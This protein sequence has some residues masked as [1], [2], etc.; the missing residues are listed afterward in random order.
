[1]TAMRTALVLSALLIL[2]PLSAISGASD[3]FSDSH[4]SDT[5]SAG[6]QN[7]VFAGY[8]NTTHFAQIYYPAND[9]GLGQ[10][11]DNASGPYPLLIWIGDEGEANDQYDWIGKSLATAGYITVV[12]PPDWNSQETGN[13][14][15]SILNLWFRLQYNNQN[16]SLQGDPAN[17]RDAFNLNYWGIGGHGVGAKQAV[18][19]Q[20]LMTG[21]LEPYITNPP[22][23]AFIGLGLED[24]STDIRDADLGSSPEPGMG[25]YLT[26][27]LDNM[28]KANTNVEVWLDEHEI[29][30]HYMSVIG[31]NHLQYQ[32][33]Q[34]FFQGW[35][36]GSATMEREEQQSH[37]I[38]H[39]TPYLDLMLKGNHDQWFNATNRDV[40]WQNPSD[41]DAYI[42]EDLEGA[43]FMPMSANSSDVFELDGNSGRAISVSTTLTH[44]N[45]ALPTGTTV[46]CTI[47][48]GGDWWDPM[49]YTTYGINAT[50]TFTSSVEN[51]TL[52]ST[53]CEVSTEGVPPGNRSIRVDV[54]WYG[55][56]SELE[57]DFFRQNRQPSVSSSDFEILVPQHGL[58]T[59]PYSDFVN[60]PDGT[61]PLIEMVPHL[62]STNQM[63][64]YLE[65]NALTC[66]HTGLP[67][68][69]GSEIL[70]LTVFDRYD[71]NFSMQM[72][73]TATVFPVDDSIVQI[74]D[75]PDL[76]MMEDDPR[77]VYT[78]TSHFEDP[79]G[80]NATI[81]G[82]IATE[83]LT[84]TWTDQNVAI[85]PL[86]NWHGSTTVEVLVSDGTT[87]PI[88]A[89]FSVDVA[90]IPDSPILNSTRI[91]VIED[92]PLEIPLTE[93]GWDEDGDSVQF[94]IEGDHPHI[95]VQIL[96]DVLR[97]VPDS[98]WSG[99]STG[100]NLTATS[101]DGNATAAIEFEV[102][103]VN[104]PIQ[105]VWGPL[106]KID[107]KAV[108]IV[109][110]HDP[111]NGAPWIVSTKWDGLTWSEFEADC[112]ASDPNAESSQDWECT[113]SVDMGGLLPGAHR[114]EVKVLENENWSAIKEYFPPAVPVPNVDSN[115]GDIIP[116][117]P[118]ETGDEPFSIWV[119]FAIVIAAV[120]AIIG[121]YMITT[122]S[123]D[124][125]ESMFG[126]SS[127]SEEVDEFAELEAEMV[128]FD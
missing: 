28:A 27:S 26:G 98:D 78:F 15:L 73:L 106:T 5:F 59:V 22:P 71:E 46:L 111:D 3:D 41:S 63:H 10:P 115:D 81:V 45:G 13:Q 31:A 53:N 60:D 67:E 117:V 123:K 126:E 128:D 68:W 55:M 20:L 88:S 79:E 38:V 70:N 29:P 42:Y 33:E 127:T 36:D 8:E 113:I 40:N 100:W 39:I 87:A 35:N 114:L 96:S 48:E 74:S 82:A 14:C 89:Y 84:L 49:D 54:D 75:I 51:G 21:I 18:Q 16:G 83:G 122:L 112:L 44:R 124:D 50:G 110:I 91:S 58:A 69:D 1:M 94:E 52:S 93:L 95:S 57:L 92:T 125:M 118:R 43:I 23:V 121:F 104:D 97:I 6:W 86:P 61:V 24:A 105:L 99:L 72:N 76:E 108:F 12:L 64:C 4:Q 119:V 30:W 90:S 37:A 19:C 120:V 17:M 107:K 101:L 80:S 2:T 109:A 32:D 7:L 56:P 62:P 34:S 85:E 25:L 9:S 11:V 102:Q 103:E 66:E 47:T 65:A 116:L 77:F